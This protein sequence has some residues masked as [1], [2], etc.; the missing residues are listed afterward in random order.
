VAL[1]LI[2]LV[3]PIFYLGKPPLSIHG[4]LGHLLLR[5]TN[6]CRERKLIARLVNFLLISESVQSKSYSFGE[7]YLKAGLSG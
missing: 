5:V 2:G 1:T 7:A 6:P 4:P 3:V